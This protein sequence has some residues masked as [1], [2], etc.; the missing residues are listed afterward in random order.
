MRMV[1]LELAMKGL[2]GGGCPWAA[3]NASLLPFPLLLQS[4]L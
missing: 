3:A 2:R 4:L 1:L